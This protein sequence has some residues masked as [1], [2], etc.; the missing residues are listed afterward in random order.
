[1]YEIKIERLKLTE[2]E[3]LTNVVEAVEV[4][5]SVLDEM[6]WDS[7]PLP[8]PDEEG[9][10]ALEELTEK[11]VKQWVWENMDRD[12]IN[13]MAIARQKERAKVALR[14]VDEQ[15][16]EVSFGIR[17]HVKPW[18][19]GHDYQLDEPCYYEWEEQRDTGE[20]DEEDNPIFET[21]QRRRF[22]KCT[23]PHTS[24]EE[25]NPKDKTTKS[26]TMESRGNQIWKEI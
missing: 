3:T 19:V 14:Q 18:R 9:F 4:H 1:M 26:N 20:V 23:H 5:V 6:I 12:K 7:I 15:T 11:Q 25:L 10:V 13:A 8:A 2:T 16:Q 22:Y 17:D 21:V 24:K